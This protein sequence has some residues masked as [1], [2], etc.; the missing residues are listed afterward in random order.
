MLGRLLGRLFA[1]PREIYEFWDGRRW[2]RVDPLV[3]CRALQSHERFNP[4][5]HPDLVDEGD[6]EA[7]VIT[8]GAVRDVFGLPVYDGKRGLTESECLSL[9]ADFWH[10]CG[11]LKKKRNRPQTSPEPMEPEH[12]DE[13]IMRRELDSGSICAV[14]S[15]AEAGP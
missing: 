3:V 2:R 10:W 11:D 7:T 13:S 9:L 5:R 4:E 6:E 12:S 1:T 15:G 8:V 14:P